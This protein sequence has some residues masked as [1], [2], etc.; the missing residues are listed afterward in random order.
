MN[1]TSAL[2][3][4]LNALNPNIPFHFQLVVSG[5]KSSNFNNNTIDLPITKMN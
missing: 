2:F 5:F 3:S 4:T 1:N